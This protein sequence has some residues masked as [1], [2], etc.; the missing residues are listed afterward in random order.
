VGAPGAPGGRGYVRGEKVD[1]QLR[2]FWVVLAEIATSLYSSESL[3]SGAG[4][5]RIYT[6]VGGVQQAGWGSQGHISG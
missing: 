1:V 4:A 2:T 5:P 6:N 3:R